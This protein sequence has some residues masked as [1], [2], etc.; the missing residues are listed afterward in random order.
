[1]KKVGSLK[2]LRTCWVCGKRGRKYFAE[3]HV[4]GAENDPDLTVWSCR[5]CHY[6]EGLLARPNFLA[7]AAA[8]GR[9][10]TLARMHKGLPDARTI[11]KYEET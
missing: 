1:M 2:P 5:G 8:V 7:D 3:H 10:I 9:L 6:L 4:M 11:V